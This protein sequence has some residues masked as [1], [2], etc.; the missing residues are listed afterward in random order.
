MKLK[1]LILAALAVISFSSCKSQYEILLN[2]NDADAKYEAAF[3]YYNEGKYSKAGSL[4][5]SLSV[6]TNGTERDD[7]VRFYWGLSNYKFRD[8]YTAETNFSNF[9]ESYPRSPFASEAR[10]LRIDCLYRSTLRYEL[11][12]TP[13]YKAITEISEY[14][15]EDPRTPHLQACRDMLQELND[16][17]DKKAYEG[18]KLYYKMEDYLASRVAF[19][20][21]LK[22][23]AENI[24][25]ED[26]LYYIAM[27]SY[28]YAHGSVPAKQ[29]ERYLTFV[30]DY[31]NFVGEIPESHYRKE[32]E[33]VYR[34]AQRALGKDA[35]IENEDMT[36]KDFAKERRKLQREERKKSKNN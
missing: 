23:D 28:N 9:L 36:E 17:L 10:Y 26:I 7:T 15:I 11:D 24:Y 30:D 8:Y 5:E 21:V 13:T 33:N 16:R 12:Q 25:R 29:K 34:K 3:K 35:A 32:L 18:A 31:L 19:R 6:L 14:I 20:N 22:D 27:S 2:S 1:N 4:F